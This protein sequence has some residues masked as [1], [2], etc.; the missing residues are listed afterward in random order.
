MSQSLN[1]TAE[2]KIVGKASFQTTVLDYEE[3]K[4]ESWPMRG[5]EYAETSCYERTLGLE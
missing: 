2:S 1:C 5:L 4:D 3:V